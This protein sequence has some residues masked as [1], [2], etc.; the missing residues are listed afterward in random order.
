CGQSKRCAEYEKKGREIDEQN[1]ARRAGVEEALVD[2]DKFGCEK[3]AGSNPEP[4][5]AITLEQHD[6][7]PATP[8]SDQQR[9]DRRANGGLRQWRNVVDRTLGRHLL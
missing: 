7:T 9:R 1:G 2:E 8:H 6:S 4:Q 5:R 3:N